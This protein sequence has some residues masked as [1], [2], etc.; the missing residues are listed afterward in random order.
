MAPDASSPSLASFPHLPLPFPSVP[1]S[2]V[3][4][5]HGAAAGASSGVSATHVALVVITPSAHTNSPTNVYPVSH[6][7]TQ[8]APDASSP[9]LASFPQLPSPFPLV[10]PSGVVYAHAAGPA[11]H[12]AAIKT[13]A[14]EHEDVEPADSEYPS[15]HAGVHDSPAASVLTLLP[16][17]Q[18]PLPVPALPLV[19]FVTVQSC[20]HVAFVRVPSEHDVVFCPA[21]VDS[22]YPLSHAGTHDSPSASAVTPSQLPALPLSGFD[23]TVHVVSNAVQI[24]PVIIPFAHEKAADNEYP[25]LHVGVH[26]PPCASSLA[27]AASLQPSPSVPLV[28]VA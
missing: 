9:S 22:E 1:P 21:I 14:A 23:M 12:V 7:G 8:V 6:S 15:L 17:L 20:T 10:P 5:G 25:E 27:V 28:G 13:P 26:V 24:P 2:G 18:L 19:G 11:T 3:V 4:Y 16:F